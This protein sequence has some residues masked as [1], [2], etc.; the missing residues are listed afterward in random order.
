MHSYTVTQPAWLCRLDY[1]RNLTVQAPPTNGGYLSAL[2]GNNASGVPTPTNDGYLSS[3]FGNSASS[4]PT[5]E[6]NGGAAPLET[7]PTSWLAKLMGNKN[8]DLQ[9]DA[10]A[11]PSD[12]PKG[13]SN[14]RDSGT[15][16]ADTPAE[17]PSGVEVC[18]RCGAIHQSCTCWDPNEYV[19]TD[20]GSDNNGDP[21][22]ASEQE[23]IDP[24]PSPP[25]APPVDS[26][27]FGSCMATFGHVCG[28]CEAC[29][30]IPCPCTQYR[31]V[32]GTRI[33]G[34]CWCGHL[35]TQHQ[36]RGR[37]S[38]AVGAPAAEAQPSTRRNRHPTAR[39]RPTELEYAAYLRSAEG[40][41]AALDVACECDGATGAGCKL[42]L[43]SHD[44]GVMPQQGLIKEVN[45]WY[46]DGCTKANRAGKL[47]KCVND[48]CKCIKGY[49]QDR[50][51]ELV[52]QMLQSFAIQQVDD[53][54]SCRYGALDVANAA[55][56]QTLTACLHTV[57]GQG[58]IS[59]SML[60]LCASLC[61]KHRLGC[62]LQSSDG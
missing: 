24:A 60:G 30:N 9:P 15:S 35:I 23:S 10:E 42:G 6:G 54:G 8:D 25:R 39:R 36:P 2:F 13:C 11:A 32:P 16:S 37:D 22:S 27:L 4:V 47:V 31:A 26:L 14:N 48:E 61:S 45:K 43:W 62:Q 5:P 56:I 52:F 44:G 28:G 33:G 51:A 50:R 49:T 12:H 3:L 38:P 41:Q 1:C 7:V 29:N 17:Q 58:S 46:G 21:M 53:N 55:C 19:A 34:E 20:S 59:N 57:A 40:L 18:E